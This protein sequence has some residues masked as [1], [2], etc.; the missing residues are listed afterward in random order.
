MIRF[1]IHAPFLVLIFL[2]IIL[3]IFLDDTWPMSLVFMVSFGVMILGLA[4][5]MIGEWLRSPA[6][7]EF[8]FPLGIGG[9]M[10]MAMVMLFSTQY[11][12]D[13][14]RITSIIIV[15]VVLG[16]V[17]FAISKDD[18]EEDVKLIRSK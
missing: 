11:G 2:G 9:V 15:V 10:A 16:L 17:S 6:E 7:R 12:T 5:S 18:D 1:V 3:F 4:V 13:V 14:L 8:G